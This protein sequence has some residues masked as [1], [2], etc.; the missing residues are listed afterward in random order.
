MP[1]HTHAC[2]ICPLRPTQPHALT[3]LHI[4]SLLFSQG[5]LE[6]GRQPSSTRLEHRRAAHSK[7]SA[8][9]ATAVDRAAPCRVWRHLNRLGPHKA[10]HAVTAA[11]LAASAAPAAADALAPA[12]AA[13]VAAVLQ[14]LRQPADRQQRCHLCLLL[15]ALV[16]AHQ[17]DCCGE[18]RG[19]PSSSADSNACYGCWGRLGRAGAWVGE[20][21]LLVKVLSDACRNGRRG[22]ARGVCKLGADLQRQGRRRKEARAAGL[23]AADRQ[24][25]ARALLNGNRLLALSS[26]PKQDV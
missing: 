5:P 19:G 11:V 12:A 3:Q 14:V 23:T 9:R 26:T 17:Q 6:D 24:W 10:V 20:E 18:Q 1:C 8:G 21:V 25:P 13:A 16:P 22:D 2:Y 15:G 4:S 7:H